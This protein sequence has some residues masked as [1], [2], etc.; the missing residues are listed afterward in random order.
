MLSSLLGFVLLLVIV[1]I[2]LYGLSAL[3]IDAAIQRVI[4]VVVLVVVALVA[5][6]FIADLFGV[7][8]PGLR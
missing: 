7:D 8:V 2:L 1:G 3:P 6:Y 5:V 4:R